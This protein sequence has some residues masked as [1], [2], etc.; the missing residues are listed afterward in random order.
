[1]K[2][3]VTHTYVKVFNPKPEMVVYEVLGKG[4]RRDSLSKLLYFV[5]PKVSDETV[6][7]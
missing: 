3:L 6:Y 7:D 2:H 5:R 1:M 4:R